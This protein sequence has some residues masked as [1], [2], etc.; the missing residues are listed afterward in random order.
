M[1]QNHDKRTTKGKETTKTHKK[2]S[3]KQK[4]AP[5]LLCS[6]QKQLLSAILAKKIGDVAENS[7]HEVERSRLPNRC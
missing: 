3:R 6:E 7:R 1:P 5:I 4:G 2:T